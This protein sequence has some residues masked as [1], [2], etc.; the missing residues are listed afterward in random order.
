[1]KKLFNSLSLSLS[2]NPSFAPKQPA[3]LRL[4]ACNIGRSMI[5]MLGV[6]AIIGVLSV[7]GLAG[8]SKA[9]AK[10]KT[11]KMIEEYNSIVFNLV[12]NYASLL[13]SYSTTTSKNS[14]LYTDAKN[15]KWLP[16]KWKPYYKSGFVYL[17]DGFGNLTHF[18]MRYDSS[19]KKRHVIMD[20]YLGKNVNNFSSVSEFPLDV[21]LSFFNDWLK[22]IS[23]VLGY[24]GIYTTN[25]KTGKG[26]Y[27]YGNTNCGGDRKCLD[28]MTLSDIQN[29]CKSCQEDRKECYIAVNFLEY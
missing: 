21:C 2:A 10:Y 23:N 12:E 6:L 1:M 29:L 15:L 26:S 20:I 24:A 28:T 17:D 27:F 13:K 7:G 25:Y 3:K 11:N 22:P 9:M 16:E 5:E 8:Y 14:E 4:Q 19:I 18:Y